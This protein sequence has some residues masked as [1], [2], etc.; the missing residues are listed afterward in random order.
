MTLEEMQEE[1]L[2]TQ[3][4]LKK[5]KA[6]NVELTTKNQEL[7]ARNDK[8]VEH[9]NKLFSR[10]SQPEGEESKELSDEEQEDKLIASIR[11][12]MKKFN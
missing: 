12:K 11:E 3:E 1:L 6:D 7:T 4:E 8:L 2:K 9:N 5:A 10:I